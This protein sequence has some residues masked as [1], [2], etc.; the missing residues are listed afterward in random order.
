MKIGI[1]TL[2]FNNNYGGY[3][4]A[5][6]LMTVLKDMGHSPTIILRRHNLKEHTKWFYFKHILKSILLSI[7]HLDINLLFRQKEIYFFL[8][9]KKMISFV[10]KYI[11]PQT[12]FLYSTKEL[13]DAC[14]NKYDAFIV[15]S[16]QVWRP[17]YVPNIKNFFLDFTNGWNVRRIA[18][19]ASF[20]N[21]SPQYTEDERINCGDLVAKFNAISVREKSGLDIITNFKWKVRNKTIVLDPTMLLSQKRYLSLLPSKKSKTQNKIFCYILDEEY[22][23]NNLVNRL[24]RLLQKER[25]DFFNKDLRKKTHSVLPSIE[26]W[27]MN[28]RDAEYIV[29]D[30][31]HGMVFSLI[32]N[33]NFFV[34]CNSKRGI[35]RFKSLLEYFGLEKCIINNIKELE[36]NYKVDINWTYVNKKI[37]EGKK[38]SINFLNSTLS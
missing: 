14:Q 20:G 12:R 24:C 29:T 25:Y 16:D 1:L 3:L 9:G 8:R 18:Y 21:S 7:S 38:N 28:I 6:A 23:T 32:F 4:Q 37:E 19:A 11:Q 30:S 2:P 35:D 36:L 27:L 17:E 26:E 15:G 10:N 33:K 22:E 34:Y 13:C 31:F 5:Y